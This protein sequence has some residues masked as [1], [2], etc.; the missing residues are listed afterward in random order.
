MTTFLTKKSLGLV[1]DRIRP[2]IHRTPILTCKALD[3]RLGATLYFK[4]ES[5]Q[6]VGAFKIRGAINVLRQM[7]ESLLKKGVCTH[8]SGNHAQAVAFGA[9]EHGVPA[10]IVMPE[11]APKVKVAAVKD[12]GAKV[13]FCEAT[14]EARE[15]TAAKVIA[16]TGATF[17]H[18]Y[19]DERIV[20]GQATA[21]CELLEDFPDLDV[22]MAPVGGG[23]LLSGTAL[24]VH[25]LAPQ[26]EVIG[27]E[28]SGADDAFR[29]VRDGV[30]QPSV[31]PRTIADGLLTSLGEVTFPIIQKHVNRILLADEDSIVAAMRLIWE[32]MKI[33]IEPSAAVPLAALM[34][35]DY[36]I[37]GKKIGIILSGGNVDLG[38][39]P[40]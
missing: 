38:K 17:I 31:N 33:V 4:A 11:T 25:L 35:N 32:R 24:A 19:N 2:Y 8:S 21:A 22:V 5:M 12:Y 39:L 16:E 6:K 10:Y 1:A 34:C 26:I 27:A 3:N 15:T 30:L 40:F 20:A 7:D 14:L 36:P 13:I 9:R 37:K 18:P 29:S 23:G 28:P